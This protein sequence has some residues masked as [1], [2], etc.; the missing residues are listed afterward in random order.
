MIDRLTTSFRLDSLGWIWGQWLGCLLI[1]L[2]M[3]NGKLMKA[4]ARH[5]DYRLNLWTWLISN[6]QPP[7]DLFRCHATCSWRINLWSNPGY[8]HADS[9]KDTS[10]YPAHLLDSYPNQRCFDKHVNPQVMFPGML[11][12]QQPRPDERHW[13][14]AETY[15]ISGWEAKVVSGVGAKAFFSMDQ[16]REQSWWRMVK[17]VKYWAQGPWRII[18]FH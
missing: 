17:S 13:G 2:A 6:L 1:L 3:F 14:Y 18:M 12:M 16:R 4:E 7:V 10:I 15:K 9:G 11:L 5:A 8:E